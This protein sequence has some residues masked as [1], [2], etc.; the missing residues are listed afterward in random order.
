MSADGTTQDGLL[1]PALAGDP[2]RRYNPLLDEW[3][4]VSAGRDA[5]PWQ[6]AREP[7]VVRDRPTYLPDC[8]LC[9]G[10]VRAHGERNPAYESTFVFV[11]DFSALRPDTSEATVEM[12]L[13]RAEGERGTCRVVCFS[14][15][16]D[17]TLGAM[18]TA[19]IARVVD[20]WAEQTAELGA[21]YRWV[22]VFENRGAAM[23]ASNPHPHGQIWAGS[24]L[25][26]EA[27]RESASQA[28]APRGHRP[29]PAPRLR[30]PGVRRPARRRRDG[31][32]ARGRSV[33]GGV[34]LR[35]PRRPQAAGRPPAGPRRE[36]RRATWRASSASCSVATTG[37]SASRSR[38]RWAGTR[39]RSAPGAADH[40]AGPRPLLPAAP[41]GRGPQVHGRLRAPRRDAAR[42]HARGRRRAPPRGSQRPD[43]GDDPGLTAG[44]RGD[45]HRAQAGRRARPARPR[46]PSSR[47]GLRPHPVVLRVVLELREPERLEER[48]H[49]HAEPAAEALFSGRTSPRPGCRPRGPRPRPCPPPRASARRRCRA[50]I[51]SPC[52]TSIAWRSSMQRSW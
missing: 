9:P 2:H 3:V 27:R 15:R 40:V 28:G 23:G 29:A 49:V 38:T 43:R 35:D 6:G 8:Y 37:C 36:R 5:R 47:S 7:E 45:R 20:V 24:A 18:P 4:L 14:P 17:L 52:S 16:H 21:R 19:D 41:P 26:V 48:R 12:G 10:N 25:P 50:S 31:R 39:R 46:A 44:R 34:A 51:Q 32:V 42:P 13:L 22:Q 33:L 1:P 30:R 11:N